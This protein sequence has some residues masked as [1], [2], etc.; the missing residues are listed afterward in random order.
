MAFTACAPVINTV[1]LAALRAPPAAKVNATAA[2]LSL[3]GASMMTTRFSVL[4][5]AIPAPND[6]AASGLYRLTASGINSVLRVLELGG[7]G[8]GGVCGLVT[9]YSGIFEFLPYGSSVSGH[10]P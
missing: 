4:S 1:V 3:S 8:F 5:E 7:P 9:W 6:L 10:R 2:T